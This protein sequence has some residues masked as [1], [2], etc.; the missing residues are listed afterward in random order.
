[1]VQRLCNHVPDR[2]R[3]SPGSARPRLL[4]WNPAARPRSGVVLADTTWFRRD[5]LVGPPGEGRLPRRGPGAKP[6]A[7]VSAD[8]AVLSPQPVGRQLGQRRLDADRHYPDQDEVDV[9]RVALS[10]PHLVGLGFELLT[11]RPGAEPA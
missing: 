9:V 1:A 10:A 7:L 3:E 4:L 5:V 8:G 11:P 6:F 2:A